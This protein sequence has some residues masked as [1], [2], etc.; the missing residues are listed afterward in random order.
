MDV[1]GLPDPNVVAAYD[2]RLAEITIGRRL[3]KSPDEDVNL[4]VFS[5]G[6]AETDRMAR[7]RDWLRS[8]GADRDL[9][10]R[11]KRELA[12]RE[13]TYVQQYADAKTDVIAAIEV[14]AKPSQPFG[15][16]ASSSPSSRSELGGLSANMAPDPPRSGHLASPQTER[17]GADPRLP[18]R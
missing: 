6:C 12:A 9:Y 15:S 11:A 17:E 14:R 8:N 2:E 4:H 5:G 1:M 7:F 16:P 18:P 3:F 13:W 10:A